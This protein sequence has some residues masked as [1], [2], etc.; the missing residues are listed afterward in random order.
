MR[1]VQPNK[2]RCNNWCHQM[3]MYLLSIVLMPS[4]VA[5]QRVIVKGFNLHLLSTALP[6]F[7]LPSLDICT[8]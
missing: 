3:G 6:T 4:D 2:Y 5:N 7:S 1:Q 8:E